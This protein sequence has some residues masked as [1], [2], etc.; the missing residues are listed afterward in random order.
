MWTRG[1]ATAV[2]MI[3]TPVA[4]E[5]PLSAIPWLSDSVAATAAPANPT[6]ALPPSVDVAPLDRPALDAAGSLPARSAGLP[7][8]LWAQ[9]EA[10]D[11]VRAIE[12][13]PRDLPPPLA[14]LLVRLLTVAATPPQGGDGALLTAR[15]DRLLAMGRLAEAAD[16]VGAAGTKRPELFRRSF[17][18]QLLTGRE[19]FGCEALSQRPDVSPTYPARIFCLARQGDWPAAAL[20]LE[21]ATALGVLDAE[22]DAILA[23]FL[24]DG[25]EDALPPPQR[26]AQITPL[27]FRMFEAIGEPMPT[28]PLP[29]PFAHADL[30]PNIGWKAR[31]EA[32]ERLARAGAIPA[33]TLM[34]LYTERR[35]AASGAPWDR[36]AAAQALQEALRTGDGVARAAE[37]AWQAMAAAD[38][39]QPLADAFGAELAAADDAGPAA[40]RLALL[41]PR[42]EDAARRAEGDPE[43]GFAAS[44]AIGQPAAPPARDPAAVA[45]RDGWGRAEPPAEAQRLIAAGR[46]GEA[47]LHAL[48]QFPSDRAGDPADLAEALATLRSLGLESVARR[49]ALHR[50][51][52]APA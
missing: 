18:I 13:L 41:G 33:E 48:G 50:L 21:T 40:L 5:A 43:L 2:M 6:S 20:T 28:G 14:D 45:V 46:I 17:D 25:I 35:P 29:L 27:T 36:A 34:A 4:A 9:S 51:L 24:A 16:L 3:A 23:R 39:L 15:V 31:L 1:A 37:T 19:S 12:G 47:I 11:L 42:Y 10:A 8:D 7:A 32:G 44:V 49:A 52:A 22:D 30:R 38:L 26:P